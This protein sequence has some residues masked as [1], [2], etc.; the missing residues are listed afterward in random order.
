MSAGGF[1]DPK[2]FDETVAAVALFVGAEHRLVY[3]KAACC[4]LLGARPLGLP[5][6]QAFSE[7]DAAEFM[8]VLDDVAAGRPRRMTQSR[9]PDPGAVE[10]ARY[11][12][13]SCT[14]VVLPD[15]PGVMVVALDTTA[16]T[17][18]LER[19]RALVSAVSQMVWVLHADGSA[20]EVVPGW[21]ELTGEP[22]HG[23]TEE[24]WYAY[25]HP[26]DRE[27]LGRAWRAAAAQE[28]PG[29]MESTFR[30]RTA[31]GSYHHMSTRCVPVLRHGRAEEWVAATVDVE[32][33]WRAAL[34][35]R[36][37]ARVAEV[38]AGSLEEVFAPVV[39]AVVPELAD[40][41][42][43]LLL[44]H[45]EWPL[46][47]NSTVTARRVASEVRP[48]LPAAPALRSQSVTVTGAVRELLEG[49]VPRTFRFPAT[50]RFPD[51]L[52]PAVTERWLSAAGA[53]SL[54]L[55]PLVLDGTVLGYAAT[56][57]NGD[58]PVPGPHDVELLRKVLHLAQ[59]P[60]HRVLD[61]Q[62]A[63]HTALYLQHAHLIE[64]PVVPGASLA[65]CYQPAS[66]IH[67]IG[68][69]WYD[70]F[71]HSDGTLALDIG[72]VAGH[73][74]TAATAMGQLRSMCRGLAWSMGPDC[75][76]GT[77]LAMLD[78]AAD[79][80]ATAS[81]ATAVHTQL[82]RRPDGTWWTAWSNAGH[83]PPLLIPSE[84]APRFLTGT[85]E[86]PRC[87]STPPRTA[88][89]TRAFSLPGTPSSTTPT[90]SSKP[91]PPP[92]TKASSG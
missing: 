11:F 62:R 57:T 87:A 43:I 92:S 9:E 4:R 54:T 17:M 81:F 28:P 50:G 66:S 55:I 60:I 33:K 14:P 73:D 78:D 46:P 29:V 40:S 77:V 26:R 7:P 67:E 63:R 24:D 44:S 86:D 84:G 75:E 8:T 90:A 27:G 12:V 15:G 39:R 64:P 91:P 85:G 18:T 37:L 70:A 89:P 23:G 42:V 51:G 61:L 10:Q 58:T 20:E 35:E 38:A 48:G 59:R 13:Y 52:L 19:Y 5:A 76:P 72:D 80:L 41:C 69:D 79:G 83:P 65:A 32:E 82:R 56:S 34:H 53:T 22:W 6:R 36:V 3:Q 88:P 47:R 45:E 71:V 1:L 21:Q 30:V 74:L 25:I 68:G 31:D 16:E 49:R 2:L